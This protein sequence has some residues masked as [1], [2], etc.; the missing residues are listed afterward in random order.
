[1]IQ[2]IEPYMSV[3]KFIL[4]CLIA[5][6]ALASAAMWVKSARAKVLADDSTSGVGALMGGYLI[7]EGKN[8][9]RIDMHDTFNEQSRWN[10][11]AAYSA[12]VCAL[13]QAVMYL[14]P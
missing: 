2:N 1:M 7:I 5:L 3:L 8:G 12:A 4:T 10:S 14:L 6:S 11:Y 13:S 9:E